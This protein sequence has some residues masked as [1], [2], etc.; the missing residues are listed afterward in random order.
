[1]FLDNRWLQVKTY[2]PQ[3]YVIKGSWPTGQWCR[4][5]TK[6]KEVHGS[7]PDLLTRLSQ[8]HPPAA[9]FPKLGHGSLR[10]NRIYLSKA[11][12]VLLEDPEVLPDGLRTK[13]Q[14]LLWLS[15]VS[16]CFW[17]LGF[18]RSSVNVHMCKPTRGTRCTRQRSRVHGNIGSELDRA[19]SVT[20]WIMWIH[21]PHKKLLLNVSIKHLTLELVDYSAERFWQRL[22]GVSFICWC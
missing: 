4:H 9:L 2:Q 6:P 22:P 14:R 11:P 16:S 8:N 21:C 7:W 10:L 3:E 20:V 15:R 17:N 13:E 5:N 1:M 19:S 12:Q 18:R